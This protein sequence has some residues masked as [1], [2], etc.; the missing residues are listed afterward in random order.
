MYVCMYVCM[1]VYNMYTC[2]YVCMYTCTMYVCMYVCMAY[3]CMYVIHYEMSNPRIQDYYRHH[4]S[5]FPDWCDTHE[6]DRFGDPVTHTLSRSG[7]VRIHWFK[8]PLPPSADQREWIWVNRCTI[9]DCMMSRYN[10]YGQFVMSRAAES[11]SADFNPFVYNGK[12]FVQGQNA[13]GVDSKY[14]MI[15]WIR[16]PQISIGIFHADEYGLW[17]ISPN[18]LD[19]ITLINTET[20]QPNKTWRNSLG[21]DLFVN[22]GVLVICGKLYTFDMRER[23]PRFPPQGGATAKQVFDTRAGRGAT[24]EVPYLLSS[25]YGDITWATYNA[26]E[27]LVFGVDRGHLVTWEVKWKRRDS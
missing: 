2:M 22:T 15:N 20:L 7:F 24:G 3:T 21:G 9:S 13:I 18:R 8:D 25:L 23:S 26:R 14:L 16:F 10:S 17:S 27:R 11:L 12:T 4:D 5:I 1:Y 6:F 19:N